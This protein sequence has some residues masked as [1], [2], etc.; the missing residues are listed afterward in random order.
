MGK[1]TVNKYLCFLPSVHNHVIE[2]SFLKHPNLI[3]TKYNIIAVTYQ[4]AVEN[5]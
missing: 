3:I 5:F 1:Q 4:Y 2:I